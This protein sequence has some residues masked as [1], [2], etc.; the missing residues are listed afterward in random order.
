M[1]LPLKSV[2]KLAGLVLLLAG[3]LVLASQ[4]RAN[5]HPEPNDTP[6][7]Q[8]AHVATQALQGPLHEQI[9]RWASAT[10]K[11]RWL[12]YAVPAVSGKGPIC[13]SNYS[14]NGDTY[15]SACSLENNSSVHI[16]PPS[17]ASRTV[18]LEGH[19]QMAV[20]FRA[21]AGKLNRIREFSSDCVADVGG[22]D[23]LWLEGIAPTESVAFLQSIV[24]A[25]KSSNSEESDE[26][27]YKHALVALALHADSAADTAMQSFVTP[28]R[29]EWLRRDTAFWLGEARGAAGL[30]ALQKMAHTDP[31]EHVRDQVTF[32]LSVSKEPGAVNEMIRM[33]H[34]DQS[35]HVRGQA[36][37]WLAHKAGKKAE[38]TITGALENDPDTEVKKKAVFAL[39]QMP[40][41]EGIPKLIEVAQTNKNPEVRK[42]AMFWLGQSH[43]PRALAFF[44][45]ILSQ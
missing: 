41:D 23:V 33:A 43:D 14:N 42:Q 21:E 39:S 11:P 15:C 17:E 9:E 28:N 26:S 24:A 10:S 19:G 36:L 32:A 22:L 37:F 6:Q 13:C 8:N 45:K 31:S 29:P 20:M 2:R 40:R 1:L 7:F 38:A 12:G 30:T 4:L 3:L 34:E 25:A 35:S 18:N 44:E 5:P 16:N 27:L